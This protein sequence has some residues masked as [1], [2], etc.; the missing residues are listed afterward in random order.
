[1]AHISGLVAAK[2]VPSPFDYADLVT[3]T[4]HKSLRGVRYDTLSWGGG[5]HLSGKHFHT[6]LNSRRVITVVF[7]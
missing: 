7:Q 1:M 4:T 3:S 6:C 2:A 5:G